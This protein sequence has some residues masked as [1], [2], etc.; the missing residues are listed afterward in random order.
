MDVPPF[1]IEQLPISHQEERI[2]RT[3]TE[4]LVVGWSIFFLATP[5]PG[6]Q[7]E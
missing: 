4:N 3:L 1:R 7:P 5:P 2:R 6:F